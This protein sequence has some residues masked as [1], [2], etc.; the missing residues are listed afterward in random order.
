MNL[1]AIRLVRRRRAMPLNEMI[2]RSIDLL[3]QLDNEALEER[4]ELSLRRL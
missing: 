1:E 4:G 2:V 3:V